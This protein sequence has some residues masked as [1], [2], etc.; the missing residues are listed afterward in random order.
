MTTETATTLQ[1]TAGNPEFVRASYGSAFWED[2]GHPA[3]VRW[4]LADSAY[5]TFTAA[6]EPDDDDHRPPTV[7]LHTF[8]TEDGVNVH[9]TY[10]ERAVTREQVA[11]FARNLLVIVDSD[12]GTLAAQLAETVATLQQHIE[13]RAEEIAAP[14]IAEARQQVVE[15]MA[16]LKRVGEFHQQRLDDLRA[17]HARELEARDAQIERLVAAAKDAK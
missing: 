6:D 11:E 15:V 4:E 7:E 8:E 10:F 17:E 13:Q 5:L 14:R 12:A 1:P 2:G 9:E 16:E 3:H